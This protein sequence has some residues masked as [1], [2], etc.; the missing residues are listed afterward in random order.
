MSNERPHLTML[1]IDP[2]GT[3]G[4]RWQC[5]ACKAEGRFNSLNA[6]DCAAPPPPPCE[7]CG[8]TPYCDLNCM[9]I[10]VLLASPDVHVVGEPGEVG[11]GSTP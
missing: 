6:T 8:Q 11:E 3:E 4:R 9:G 5:T 10:K 1:P 2:K 7:W